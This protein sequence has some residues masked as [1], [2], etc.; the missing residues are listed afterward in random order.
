MEAE[1]NTH[2]ASGTTTVQ[3][4]RLSPA[5]GRCAPT[6]S[7][8]DRRAGRVSGV[9]MASGIATVSRRGPG[10]APAPEPGGEPAP[11]PAV[12]SSLI[13]AAPELNAAPLAAPATSR[14]ATSQPVPSPP[15]I[16]SPDPSSE[17]TSV[18]TSTR[19]RPYRSD[20][21]PPS[22]SPGISPNTYTP[23]V[24]C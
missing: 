6:P 22:N 19:R 23:K 9:R 2:G 15:R 12:L 24:A 11:E 3:N 21:G 13:Q 8:A 17:A 10:F 14:P 5:D 20:T 18:G 7:G 4:R 16:S 1:P